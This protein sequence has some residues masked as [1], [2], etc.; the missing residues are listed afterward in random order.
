[1]SEHTPIENTPIIDT[2]DNNLSICIL[3]IKPGTHNDTIQKAIFKHIPNCRYT[4]CNELQTQPVQPG[5]TYTKVIAHTNE[6]AIK[7][8]DNIYKK[9]QPSTSLYSV[10]TT[11]NKTA[12]KTLHEI[13]WYHATQ[14]CTVF[15]WWERQILRKNHR[16][17]K[18][19]TA[20]YPSQ[21]SKLPDSHSIR[22]T[23][24]H[25]RI[26]IPGKTERLLPNLQ[27]PGTDKLGRII[28]ISGCQPT[29]QSNWHK[30]PIINFTK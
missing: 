20:C 4:S 13:S 14:H 1:M 29:R 24:G 15:R 5:I 17:I 21:L 28:P 26:K 10:R 3:N 9:I 12:H 25:I 23:L 27:A 19:I 8:I 6:Q 2:I 30:T 11:F 22:K 16:S 7:Q 18:N